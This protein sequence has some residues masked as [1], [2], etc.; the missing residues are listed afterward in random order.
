M[1]S[2]TL[3]LA[4]LLAAFALCATAF[5]PPALS[6]CLT[7]SQRCCYAYELCGT[8][9]R[10]SAAS[11]TCQVKRCGAECKRLCKTDHACKKKCDT[12]SCVLFAGACRT[13]TTRVYPSFCPRL[14]CGK[15]T[16]KLDAGVKKPT[17][18]VDEAQVK[19]TVKRSTTVFEY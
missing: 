16:E 17:S 6:A 12:P 8:Q 13:D 1:A 7:R 4:A 3:F 9:T 10:R 18:I 19:E 2:R 5:T 14:T 15:L 11:S